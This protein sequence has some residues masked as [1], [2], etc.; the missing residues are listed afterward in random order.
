MNKIEFCASVAHEVNRR[1]CIAN[2]DFSQTSWE[3]AE[4]WQRDSAMAG[5]GSALAGAT[6]EQQ[7]H[8]WGAAKLA[9]GWRYGPIKDAVG[10]VHPCLVPYNKLSPEQ[11]AKDALFIGVVRVAAG[12][13]VRNEG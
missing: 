2:G 4:Q 11:Q 12:V 3:D 10:K 1:W 7:H 5:V 8:A 6:P 9:D 13:W